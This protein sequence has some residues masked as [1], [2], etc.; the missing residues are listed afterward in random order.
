MGIWLSCSNE[1]MPDKYVSQANRPG[2]PRPTGTVWCLRK[3]LGQRRGKERAGNKQCK[4]KE[5]ARTWQ[6]EGR[7]RAGNESVRR[8]PVLFRRSAA[9]RAIISTSKTHFVKKGCA[10]QGGRDPRPRKAM[11]IPL[12]CTRTR[13]GYCRDPM[14]TNVPAL[15]ATYRRGQPVHAGAHA[16]VCASRRAGLFACARTARSCG[17]ARKSF[18][19]H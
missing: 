1:Q 18:A 12:R 11:S 15:V 5:R 19:P 13:C 16:F 6:G 4:G 17:V 9:K 10:R 14:A 7:E 2:S 3:D 8:A